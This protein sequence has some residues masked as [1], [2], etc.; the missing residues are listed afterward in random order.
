MHSAD[1]YCVNLHKLEKRNMNKVPATL[2]LCQVFDSKSTCFRSQGN[3]W[4]ISAVRQLA[5]TLLCSFLWWKLTVVHY[6]EE[7]LRLECVH[8]LLSFARKTRCLRHCIWHKTRSCKLHQPVHLQ[9]ACPEGSL[10]Y[11]QS[12]IRFESLVEQYLVDSW[13]SSQYQSCLTPLY[14]HIPIV[15]VGCCTSVALYCN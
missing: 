12:R 1:S 4:C 10:C 8:S 2:V 14:L 15:C 3:F 9:Q 13:F 6:P 11:L 7:E 5:G